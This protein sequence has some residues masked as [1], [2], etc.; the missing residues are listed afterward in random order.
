MKLDEQMTRLRAQVTPAWTDSRAEQVWSGLDARRAQRRR[1]RMLATAALLVLVAG[2]AAWRGRA[3]T[4]LP[5]V[6]HTV[7]RPLMTGPHSVDEPAWKRLAEGGDW[8]AAFTALRQSNLRDE[9]GDLVLAAEV[10]RRSGHP[11]DALSPLQRVL[12]QHAADPHAAHAALL[13]GRVLL[14]DLSLPREAALAF[15]QVRLLPGHGALDEDALAHEAEAWSRAG[16]NRRA[17]ARAREYL[18]RWPDG[19]QLGAVR[20]LDATDE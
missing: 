8:A 14:E 12:G 16:D 13:L 1:Q 4:P 5:V 9:A 2:V 19:A 3:T 17:T 11:Y 18:R 7:R 15:A 10:A 6:A 20:P